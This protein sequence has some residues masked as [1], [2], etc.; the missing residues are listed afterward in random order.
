M[1]NKENLNLVSIFTERLK[2]KE[3]LMFK[4]KKSGE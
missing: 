2:G 3:F 4:S 1:K